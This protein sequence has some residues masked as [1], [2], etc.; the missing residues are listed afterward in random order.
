[1]HIFGLTGGIATGKSTVAARL[2]AI[3]VPV[4]DA[5][6]VAR[7]VVA[8]GTPGLEAI[9]RAFGPSVIDS[10]GA[11]DRKALGRVVFESPAAR[12][13]LEAIT[14]PLIAARTAELAEGLAARGE[15]IACYEAALLAEVGIADRYRPLVVCACPTDLQLTRLRARD[16]LSEGDALARVRAQMPLEAK[17]AMADRVLDTSGSVEDTERRA[18]ELLKALC[19]EWGVDSAR[20]TV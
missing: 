14:H 16:G 10:R 9:A 8:L 17:V 15:P 6:A 13:A 12:I 7:D 5:D 19:L 18:D 2:R 20:Y 3:G 1:M 11:V 4:L